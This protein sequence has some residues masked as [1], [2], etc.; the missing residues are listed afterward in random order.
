MLRKVSKRVAQ[1]QGSQSRIR[2]LSADHLTCRIPVSVLRLRLRVLQV[3]G[4]VG[5]WDG[6]LTIGPV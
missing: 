2:N 5:W 1:V 6:A 3:A 4:V